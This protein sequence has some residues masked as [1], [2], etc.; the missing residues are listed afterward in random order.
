MNST[1]ILAFSGSTRDGS[2]NTKLV[3]SAAHIL[4]GLKCEVMLISLK[5]YSLP[6]YD[7]D[8]ETADGIPENAIKLAQIMSDHDGFFIT[9]PEYNGSL[10]P[11]LKNVIDWVSRVPNAENGLTPYKDKVAAIG[12][13]S[14]GAMGGISMLYHLRQIL[15]R[16]GTLVISEQVAVGNAFS[17]FNEDD[18]LKDERTASFLKAVCASL[19]AKSQLMKES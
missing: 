14:P 11:L 8:L 17:G 13:A 2:V 7:G 15:V 9:S 1:K 6:I 5:D 18:S 19:V 4:N 12:A 16:L 10:S 3:K